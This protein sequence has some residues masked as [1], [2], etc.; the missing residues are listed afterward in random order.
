MSDEDLIQDGNRLINHAGKKGRFQKIST[1]FI[2]GYSFIMFYNITSL[3]LQKIRPVAVCR[4]KENIFENFLP[5]TQESYCDPR[6][7]KIIKREESINNWYLD[8]NVD[9]QTEGNFEFIISAIFFGGFLSYVGLSTWADR[10]GRK[11]VLQFEVYGLLVI[12]TLALFA[13]NL[14]VICFLWFCYEF[15]NH[16]Y[17]LLQIYTAE[18]MSQEYFSVICSLSNICFPLT[19]LLTS[20]LFYSIRD[21]RIVHLIFTS[22]ALVCGVIFKFYIV[23][24]PP[25]SLE[26]KDIYTFLLSIRKIAQVNGTDQTISKEINEFENKY[27]N[28]GSPSVRNVKILKENKDSL[29]GFDIPD[30][31]KVSFWE[32]FKNDQ[33]FRK[34][35]L[36]V[37]FIYCVVQ[38][39]FYGVLLNIEKFSE[40]VLLFSILLYTSEISAEFIS[41]ILSQK[42]GRIPVLKYSFYLSGM[43]FLMFE[44][45][46]QIP[47]IRYFFCFWGNFGISSSFNVMTIYIAE[48]FDVKI[49]STAVA[50]SK[51]PSQF[52]VIFSP[53]IISRLSYPFVNFCV[54]LCSCGYSIGMCKE[55]KIE[56][57]PRKNSHH[58][59]F[60]KEIIYHRND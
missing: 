23:E 22:F 56:V 45:L 59:R 11:R 38:L 7:E 16:V 17:S 8:F 29:L 49:R 5:C 14:L 42:Y 24:T 50:Y 48:V 9:C 2:I 10:F 13:R 31:N 54:L 3:P 53:Y 58:S 25:Y 6:Y 32:V 43:S 30:D 46:T 4:I 15:C 37:L 39:V 44:L 51:I 57:A 28:L 35:F 52:V 40:N 60:S 21:W 47:T 26:K 27:I 33:K 12:I 41:G 1:I 55:T 19:G 20:I 34:Q 18:T 36:I